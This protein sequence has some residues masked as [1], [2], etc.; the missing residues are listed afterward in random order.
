MTVAAPGSDSSMGHDPRY[1][2]RGP[3]MAKRERR[4]A[5]SIWTDQSQHRCVL[6]LEGRLCAETV[7]LLD[8]HVDLLGCQ[9][10]DE[11][12]LDMS[13][14]EMLDQVGARLVVGLGHYVAGRDGRFSLSGATR[15]AQSMIDAA[16]IELSS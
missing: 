7:R 2:R 8:S 1:A 6:R 3:R 13:H 4:A 15:A 16:E 12:V 14:V 9:S 5:L 11:V 10:C